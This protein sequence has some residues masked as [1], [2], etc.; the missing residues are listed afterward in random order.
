M[1]HKLLANISVYINGLEMITSHSPLYALNCLFTCPCP[2]C[3]PICY[4][5]IYTKSLF[6]S[7]FFSLELTVP[8]SPIGY[9]LTCLLCQPLCRF[10]ELMKYSAVFWQQRTSVMQ[11]TTT[12]WITLFLQTVKQPSVS[13][14]Q[15][16][17]QALWKRS[18]QN[19]SK[20]V[21]AV[22]YQ[23]Y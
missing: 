22:D 10:T 17:V 1:W 23:T 20:R 8:Q 12:S 16:Q 6:F 21:M 11:P 14:L 9:F 13:T 3:Y 7:F 18:L 4:M 19:H 5:N 15:Q 2:I